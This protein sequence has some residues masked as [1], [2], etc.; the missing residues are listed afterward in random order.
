[1]AAR[2]NALSEIIRFWLQDCHKL[3]IRESV[4]V[5]LHRS[6]SDIDFMATTGGDNPVV[7]LNNIP[8]FSK[9]IIESKDER[10]YDY[11]GRNFRKRIIYDKS[12]MVDA[13]IPK[14]K[15]CNFTMLREE[16]HEV[17]K[18]YF[19]TD[20]FLKIFIVHH[21][22][23]DD[24]MYQL[25]EEMKKNNIYF[26]RSYEMLDDIFENFFRYRE[27]SGIRNSLVGDIFD[28]LIRYHK[29]HPPYA[30]ASSSGKV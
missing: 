18:E 17:A 19:N 6:L 8:S 22:P 29:W 10:D 4:P 30:L 15:K 25:L 20:D 11:W 26:I 12:V 13:V 28:F 21:L 16:H 24:E 9:A 3:F 23:Q 7:L 27:N 14:G 2:S 1:M 5:K